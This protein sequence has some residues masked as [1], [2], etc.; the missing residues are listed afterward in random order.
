M[1]IESSATTVPWQEN[2]EGWTSLSNGPSPHASALSA[3]RLLAYVHLR[4]IHASTGAGRVARQMIEHLA[5][6][7][8]VELKILAD[9]GDHA[10]VLPLVG[11]PWDGFEYRLFNAD[12]SRQQARWFALDSPL[13]EGYWPES[14]IVFCTAESYVPTRKARL[15]VT[16]HDAAFFEEGAHH[17]NSAFWMQRLKW[18][19]LYEKLGRKADLFHTVSHFSAERLAHFFPSIRSRL[20]VVHNAVTP[21]FFEPLPPA[22]TKYLVSAGLRDKPFILVPGGLHHR[23]NAELILAASAR[24][25]RRF[26]ALTIVVVNHSDPA[27]AAQAESLGAKFCVLGFV[28]DEALHALYVAAQVVWFPSRYEGFGLPVI[29]AMAC[30]TPVVASRASSIPEIAGESALLVDPSDT[31]AHVNAIHDLLVDCRMCA[32]LA[33]RGRARAARF[34]WTHSAE[35]LKTCFDALL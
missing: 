8:D 5:Q 34:T 13:A 9:A 2:F 29:E 30:G 19:L 14:Q 22:G 17:R 23:K 28:P 18:K 21:H 6:R 25:Q 20:R 35:Q 27:Y 7:K 26:P 31:E 1:A 4:N 24:L 16:L 32:E 3:M 11:A 15:C 33:R 12:T 10:R